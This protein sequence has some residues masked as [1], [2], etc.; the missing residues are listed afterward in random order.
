MRTFSA[1]GRASSR[2]PEKQQPES[3]LRAKHVSRPTSPEEPLT[4]CVDRRCWGLGTREQ[5]LSH[6]ERCTYSLQGPV[7]F[8]GTGYLFIGVH[9]EEHNTYNSV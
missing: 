6:T 3:Y 8:R 9:G 4:V 5:L 1:V 2:A 7:R